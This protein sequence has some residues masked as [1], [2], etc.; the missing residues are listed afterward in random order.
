MQKL[1][2]KKS[3]TLIELLV[4]IAIIAILAAMLLPALS[5]A[6][7]RARTA[8]CTAKLKQIGLAD[9]MY[10]DS[11]ADFRP[12]YTYSN[13]HIMQGQY[14]NKSSVAGWLHTP[15]ALVAGGFFGEERNAPALNDQYE[16]FFKC[17]SDT[18]VYGVESSP[19]A[20][21]I[22]LSYTYWNFNSKDWVDG[23]FSKATTWQ[24]KDNGT[25]EMRRR[26]FAGDNPSCVIWNDILRDYPATGKPHHAASANALYMG[27]HVTTV[28][29]KQSDF[30]YCF[31]GSHYYRAASFLDEI[32]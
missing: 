15:D 29:M 8:S 32:K 3:F 13:M 9:K 23:K 30:D 5:A 2:R 25:E 22:Y 12:D 7:E 19:G 21:Q 17:P 1:F 18:S 20:Q 6:R 26:S 31:S 14:F 4:V 27:G 24:G 10:T 11:N 28:P 16:K